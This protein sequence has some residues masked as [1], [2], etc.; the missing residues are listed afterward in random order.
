MIF[1]VQLVR[2]YIFATTLSLF[3]LR[4]ETDLDVVLPDPPACPP[5]GES[6]GREGAGG[7]APQSVVPPAGQRLLRPT[8]GHCLGA[9]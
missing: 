3:G 9:N 8:D 7:G 6:G 5:P 2:L 4:A 1:S